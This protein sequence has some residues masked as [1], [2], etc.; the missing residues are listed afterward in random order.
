MG[1]AITWC[2]VPEQAAEQFLSHLNL[3]TTGATED[4]PESRFS[5]ARLMTGWRLI[6]SNQYACPVLAK[7]LSSYSG[8]HEVVMCQIEDHVSA[9]SA[10]LW[11]GGTRKWW[12]SHEGE[13]GET[14]LETDG[15][16]PPCFASIRAQIEDAQGAE[17]DDDADVDYISDIPLKVAQALAGFK[18]DEKYEGVVDGPFLVLSRGKGERGFL[19]RLFGR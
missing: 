16:L 2:A 8:A 18:H 3:V 17:G 11:T 10:E 6:W 5:M 13:Q 9:C 4:D 19:S 1:F 15:D 12:V 14:H 7:R